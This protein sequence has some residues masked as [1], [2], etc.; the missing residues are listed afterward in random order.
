[1]DAQSHLEDCHKCKHLQD[2]AEENKTEM[3]IPSPTHGAMSKEKCS[4]IV[5]EGRAVQIL[6]QCSQHLPIFMGNGVLWQAV[7]PTHACSVLES[8]SQIAL[9]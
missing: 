1:M 6:S 5:T 8:F 3:V 7:P 2:A 4:V 9:T